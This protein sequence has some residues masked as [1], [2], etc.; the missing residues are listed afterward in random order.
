MILNAAAASKRISNVVIKTTLHKQERLSE[1]Y[2][3]NVY[4]KREDEQKVR[5]YKIRGAYNKISSL[6][7]AERKAG[8]VCASAGNHAQGVAYSCKLLHTKCW[9]FMPVDTPLQKIERVQN[10]GGT[11]VTIHLCGNDFDDSVKYAKEYCSKHNHHFIPAFEDEKII[12]GQATTA[13]EILADLPVIDYVFMPVGGGG[14]AAGVG[15]YFKQYS[16]V[17]KLIGAEPKGAASMSAAFTAGKPVTLDKVNVF[18]DGAAVKRVG[19]ITYSICKSSLHKMVTIPEGKI[20]ATQLTLYNKDGILTEPAGALSIAA[21]DDFA[22]EIKGKTVVCIVT[23]SNNDSNRMEE[24]KKLADEWEGLQ[25]YLIVRFHHNPDGLREFFTN[26]LGEDDY[27]NRIEYTRREHGRSTYALLGVRSENASSYKT[28]INR[29]K[30][31]Q[32][33]FKEV[34]K[35]DFLFK[36][37]V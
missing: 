6:T 25:H 18:V 2:G 17:T 37:W 14:L 8:V 29:M 21:L 30:R 19:D 7:K 4:L 5:S 35:D 13:L 28:M 9:V 22:E 26:I 20:C 36:Y 3:C 10:V 33:E 11:L 27:V 1:Q 24:I 34:Q 12:E 32:I 16:P 23:G 31:Q 15:S